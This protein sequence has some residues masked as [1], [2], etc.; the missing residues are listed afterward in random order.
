MSNKTILHIGTLHAKPEHIDNL[1]TSFEG[2]KQA[3]GYIS[4]ECYRDIDDSNK[5]TLVEEWRSKDDHLNFVGSFSEE[6]MEQW[7]SMLSQE[8]EDSYYEKL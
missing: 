5:V 6:E 4:H 8:G 7:L 2:L 1:I 3:P